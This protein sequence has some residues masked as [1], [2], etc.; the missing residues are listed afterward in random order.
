M[1]MSAISLEFE[2]LLSY[3]SDKSL[4]EQAFAIIFRDIVCK[5]LQIS[6]FFKQTEQFKICLP[7]N[8][9]LVQNLNVSW[10]PKAV[11]SEW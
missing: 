5:R 10:C 11:S 7:L 2:E 3:S 6:H 1:L 4:W 8:F 9:V